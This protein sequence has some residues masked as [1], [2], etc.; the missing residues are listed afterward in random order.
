MKITLALSFIVVLAVSFLSG[1]ATVMKPSNYSQWFYPTYIESEPSGARIEVNNEYI[2]KTPLTKILPR[3]YR[4]QFKGL[5]F[6][7]NQITTLG[8]VAITAYP[9]KPG[10]QTQ[11]KYIGSDQ[12][13]PR[14]IFFDMS[15]VPAN[16]P[17]KI[18][19]DI[20]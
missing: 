17:Q 6:G 15:L 14:H 13:M 3:T 16:P 5:L 18:E 1:C 4:Y 11:T 7:G 10:Q 20:N 9:V 2:G 12:A 8:S 19:L